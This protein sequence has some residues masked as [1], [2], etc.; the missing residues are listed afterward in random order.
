[1]FALIWERK[2]EALAEPL[3]IVFESS[4]P[5][6][7][8]ISVGKLVTVCKS[9]IFLKVDLVFDSKSKN[10]RVKVFA[11]E[12]VHVFLHACALL[13]GLHNKCI[14]FILIG[15]SSLFLNDV[16]PVRLLLSL[17]LLFVIFR[18]A[19]DWSR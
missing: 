10:H 17:R 5:L 2:L 7:D 11:D 16:F 8:L 6:S 1:M 13:F 19:L 3:T 14:L 15:N 18:L 9:V 4:C 12:L